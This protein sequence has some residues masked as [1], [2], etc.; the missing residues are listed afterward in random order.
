M[1]AYTNFTEMSPLELIDEAEAEIEA[2][3]KPRKQKIKTRITGFREYL[4]KKDL[5]PLSVEN[6]ITGVRSFYK[7]NDIIIPELQRRESTARVLEVHKGVP[8]KEAIRK[9]LEIADPL[10]KAIILTGVSSGLEVNEICD[11]KIS[12][13]RNGYDKETG[14]TTLSLR[15]EKKQVDFITFL[16]PE[17]SSAITDYLAYRERKPKT[18]KEEYQ[19]H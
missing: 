14:I 16:T 18:G 7:A 9:V 2:R 5:A 13:F 19:Y 3:I 4:E 8:T 11:L 10:E 6:R 1:Q 17:A 15:R 12:D